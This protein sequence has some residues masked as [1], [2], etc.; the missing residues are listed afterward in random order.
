M[1]GDQPSL[2]EIQRGPGGKAELQGYEAQAAED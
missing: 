1:K 2:G